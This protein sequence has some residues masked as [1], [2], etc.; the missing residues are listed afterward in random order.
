MPAAWEASDFSA[1]LPAAASTP[2][3]C[4]PPI[5][6]HLQRMAQCRPATGRRRPDAAVQTAQAGQQRVTHAAEGDR[7]LGVTTN[8]QGHC[9]T[10]PADCSYCGGRLL[11][12]ACTQSLSPG[13]D[14][15][16]PGLSAMTPK[17]PK[18]PRFRTSR[19]Q[20][21]LKPP[22]EVVYALDEVQPPGHPAP[23][24]DK[25]T[26]RCWPGP[27]PQVASACVPWG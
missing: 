15:R 23:Q 11:T 6:L 4:S 3:V 10:A 13:A 20:A 8:Q 18:T 7:P 16:T 21:A 22:L 14:S 17:T 9:C 2:R 24:F 19:D 25:P 27:A 1:M 26:A 5:Y 12:S